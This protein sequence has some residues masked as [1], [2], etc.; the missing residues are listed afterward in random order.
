MKYKFRHRRGLEGPEGDTVELELCFSFSLCARWDWV[1]NATPCHVTPRHGRF[2]L[3]NDTFY[4]RLGGPQ[5]RAGR[6]RNISL[7]PGFDPWTVQTVAC[8]TH[9]AIPTLNIIYERFLNNFSVNKNK[10]IITQTIFVS[11]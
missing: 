7:T 9:Y 8:H 3:E 1:V 2:T 11:I 6:L 10:V 5:G 4:M